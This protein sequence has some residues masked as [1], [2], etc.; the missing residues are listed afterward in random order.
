[1]FGYKK[2][3]EKEKKISKENHSPTRENEIEYKNY[4]N[5]LYDTFL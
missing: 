4:E 2:M 5:I 1:M 3:V